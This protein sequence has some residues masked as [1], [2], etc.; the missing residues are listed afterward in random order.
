MNRILLAIAILCAA[1]GSVVLRPGPDPVV[2]AVHP[3]A[4]EVPENLLRLYVDFSEPMLEGNAFECV[5]LLEEDGEP[6]EDAF[7]EIELWSRD[8][9]RLMVYIH[10]GRTKRGL[11]YSEERGL[12]L[13]EGKTYTLEILPG[14]VSRRSREITETVRRVF[15]AGPPDREMPDVEKWVISAAPDRIGIECGEWLDRVGLEEFVRIEN[16][17]GKAVPGRWELSGTRLVFH[18]T[19]SLADGGYRLTVNSLLEDLAGNNFRRP[20]ETK[21]G[22]TVQDVFDIVTCTFLIS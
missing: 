22:E 15:R 1:G 18:P 12:V 9:T 4:R 13:E 6:I 17:A 5:R 21:E 14:M 11:Q 3:A 10:P 16:T 2:T 7:R 19:S 20:F 8:H